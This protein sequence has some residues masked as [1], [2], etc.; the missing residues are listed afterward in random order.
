MDSKEYGVSPNMEKEL[1]YRFIAYLIGLLLAFESMLLCACC[2][3]SMI[4]GE[5]D[6][7]AFIVSFSVCLEP[8]SCCWSMVGKRSL[9]Y[10]IIFYLY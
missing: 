7:M 6:L 5:S 10:R 2:C 8:V 1:S 9:L 4:Y 3:V